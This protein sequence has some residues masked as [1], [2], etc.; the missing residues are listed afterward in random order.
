MVASLFRPVGLQELSLI[1][2]KAMREFPPRLPH[3]PI[4]Y[5]VANIAYA[6]QIARDWNT[7]DEKSGFSGFVTTFQ[8]EGSYLSKFEPHTV[9]SSSHVEYWI[10]S[11][12]LTTFNQSIIGPIRVEE[13][14]F[15]AGFTG[16]VPE[17]FGLKGMEAIAQFV[18]LCQT[19]E[20]STFDVSCEVSTNRKSVF[21][22]WLFWVQHDF[23]GFGIGQEQR[24]ELL[25]NLKKCWEFNDI[26]VPLPQNVSD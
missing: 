8:L 9:G 4:F 11:T 21:L 23:S 15:G 17:G 5:P 2:D 22:N 24:E 3:Q 10:P 16:H 7:Q 6:R 18:A 14:F 13:G 25:R 26:K 1:W 19:W 20:Y 12:D